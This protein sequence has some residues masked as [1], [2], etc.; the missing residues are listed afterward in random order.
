[1]IELFSS[2]LG[3]RKNK[4]LL[5][6]DYYSDRLNYCNDYG[7]RPMLPYSLKDFLDFRIRSEMV[8]ATLLSSAT[9]RY[10]AKRGNH[11]VLLRRSNG[12]YAGFGKYK[13][14]QTIEM[15]ELDAESG[16]AFDLV[17]WDNLRN[18]LGEGLKVP[19]KLRLTPAACIIAISNY[20]SFCP[21]MPNLNAEWKTLYFRN[22][23]PG[24]DELESC[25]FYR[26]N[27]ILNI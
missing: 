24:F 4:Y 8:I 2:L 17:F 26:D 10:Y 6:H 3:G 27:N 15:S 23:A 9:A 7:A 22:P 13:T 20:N 14:L 18:P 21:E 12:S 16:P 19:G 25:V 5:R 1:M 11:V